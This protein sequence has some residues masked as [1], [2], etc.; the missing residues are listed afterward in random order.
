MKY[1]LRSRGAAA[2]RTAQLGI[3]LEERAIVE[4]ALQD[5]KNLLS[6]SRLSPN[7]RHLYGVINAAIHSAIH[8]AGQ[9]RMLRDMLRQS[10]QSA[11]VTPK[12]HRLLRDFKKRGC[13][14]RNRR[15][16]G[17]ARYQ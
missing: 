8:T 13:S 16:S 4:A 3:S 12:C 17:A 7:D 9:S 5:G 11:V 15:R 10:Q 6:K 1:A 14:P 2:K